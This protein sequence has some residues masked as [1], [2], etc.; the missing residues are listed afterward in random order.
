MTYGV[1]SLHLDAYER[2]WVGNKPNSWHRIGDYDGSAGSAPRTSS[3]AVERNRVPPSDWIDPNQDWEEDILLSR[4]RSIDAY[5]ND[6]RSDAGKNGDN[7]D[8]ILK[9]DHKRG[10]ESVHSSSPRTSK[11]LEIPGRSHRGGLEGRQLLERYAITDLE[12]KDVASNPETRDDSVESIRGRSSGVYT[13]LSSVVSPNANTKSQLRSHTGPIM[14]LE[15]HQSFT[16]EILPSPLFDPT[17]IV[18]ASQKVVKAAAM[19]AERVKNKATTL[20]LLHGRSQLQDEKRKSS[21]HRSE[22]APVGQT[23]DVP[24]VGPDAGSDDRLDSY[25]WGEIID[26]ARIIARHYEVE[27]LDKCSSARRTE[28]KE[29]RRAMALFRRHAKELN[30][31]EKD[32]FAV[33]QEDDS[34]VNEQLTF[35]ES[36]TDGEDSWAGLGAFDN[37]LDRYVEAFEGMCTKLRCG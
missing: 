36:T 8:T 24:K 23:V 28:K 17:T 5:I 15:L 14:N 33:V 31:L 4:S 29:Y 22:A 34:V 10:V 30:M 9:S 1:D 2:D 18:E 26:T 3:E 7:D 6:N 37:S 16:N 20:D 27:L 19:N 21:R 11:S 12:A 13:R 25:D 35:D 32:L